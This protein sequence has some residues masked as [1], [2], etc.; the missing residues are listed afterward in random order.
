MLTAINGFL[1]TGIWPV[2]MNVFT[3]A[4]FLPAATTKIQLDAS[5]SQLPINDGSQPECLSVRDDSAVAERSL[6][7]PRTPNGAADPTARVRTLPAATGTSN[8]TAE[9]SA[10]R[11]NM[12]AG[13]LTPTAGTSCFPKLSPECILPAPKVAQGN[14]RSSQ[15]TRKTAILTSSPSKAELKESQRKAANKSVAKKN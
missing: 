4:H 2:D 9:L 15:K 7:A 6:E 11:S 3:E 13:T 10:A 5:S 14:K 1:R 12:A 8:T